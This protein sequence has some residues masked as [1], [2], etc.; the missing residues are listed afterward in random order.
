[1]AWGITKFTEANRNTFQVPFSE[2]MRKQAKVDPVEAAAR[3]RDRR[4]EP[5][6]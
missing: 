3:L 4:Q 1:M 6:K 5:K 2:L